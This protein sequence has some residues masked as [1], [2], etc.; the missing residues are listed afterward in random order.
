MAGSS[1]PDAG[2]PRTSANDQKAKRFY[3]RT[4]ETSQ[5]RMVDLMKQKL[6]GK[7]IVKWS[8]KGDEAFKDLG[9][10]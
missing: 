8:M 1:H 4:Y 3:F 5:I 9:T 7:E 6:D 10:P 2:R